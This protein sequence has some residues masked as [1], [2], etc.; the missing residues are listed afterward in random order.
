MYRVVVLLSVLLAIA[1]TS[2]PQIL[3]SNGETLPPTSAL[4]ESEDTTQTK[5]AILGMFHFVSE[6]NTYRQDFGREEVMS[7]RRQREIE[8]LVDRLSDFEPTKIAVERPYYTLKELNSKYR[9]YLLG[10][11][12]LTAEE[13][14][15]IAF[16]L[17]QTLGHDS[18]HLVKSGNP[19]FDTKPVQQYAQEHGET[20]WMDSAQTS[21]KGMLARL[22]SVLNAGTMVDGL[23]YFNSDEVVEENYRLYKYLARV[24][25]RGERV[26][27]NLMGSWQAQNLR[28]F[29]NIRDVAHPGDRVLVI[30]GAAHKRELRRYIR[31]ARDLEYVN[32]SDYL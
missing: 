12:D 1:F 5:I 26:G 21:A 13:T 7:P 22:D 15:Q 17:G 30:Y 31:E 16:R 18:L 6:S 23:R 9:A 19:E 28:I 14:D 2:I 8:M 4:S 20:H 10:D 27:A 32:I 24:G 29:E 11:Y 3:S 25:E